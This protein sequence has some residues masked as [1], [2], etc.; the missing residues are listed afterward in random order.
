MELLINSHIWK[1]NKWTDWRSA[2][3]IPSPRGGREYSPK[4]LWVCATWALKFV[5]YIRTKA[6][7]VHAEKNSSLQEKLSN[8]KPEARVNLFQ[9]K[10][11]KIYT[12]FRPKPLKVNGVFLDSIQL[13]LH[14]TS[15]VSIIKE[16]TYFI[17]A[18]IKYT[19]IILIRQKDRKF[20]LNQ[21]HPRSSFLLTIRS[22]PLQ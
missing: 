19:S 17:Y 20:L 21:W 5:P 14:L 11:V 18:G 10:M 16:K 6:V 1:I 8:A 12:F 3:C 4:F 9:T 2:L 15:W 7:N 13:F 22:K